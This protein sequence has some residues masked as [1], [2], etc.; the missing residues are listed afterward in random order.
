MGTKGLSVAAC[1]APAATVVVGAPPAGTVVVAPPGAVVVGAAVVVGGR[2]VGAAVVVG[3]RVVGGGVV[4]TA[5]VKPSGP[6]PGE[7]V[8]L[9][10]VAQYFSFVSCPA[11]QHA[12][13]T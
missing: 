4:S 11:F 6:D 7:A 3:G 9:T 5:H 2:V 13:P 10:F 12:I 1:A 8:T